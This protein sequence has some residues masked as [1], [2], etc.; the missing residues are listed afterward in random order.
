MVK[1]KHIVGYNIKIAY[2]KPYKVH[3][4]CYKTIAKY[5]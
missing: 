1:L 3:I 4:C 2:L 5:S